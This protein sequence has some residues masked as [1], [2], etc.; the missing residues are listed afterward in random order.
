MHAS[1]NSSH[2]WLTQQ[3]VMA[4]GGTWQQM[5]IALGLTYCELLSAASCCMQLTADRSCGVLLPIAL[6]YLYRCRLLSAAGCQHKTSFLPPP[7]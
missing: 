6:Y 5:I 3:L 1:H 7:M 2:A 4:F